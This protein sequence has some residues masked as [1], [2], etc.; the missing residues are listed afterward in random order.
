MRVGTESVSGRANV[1][2]INKKKKGTECLYSVEL[3][4]A[5][6]WE[7]LL[8]SVYYSPLLL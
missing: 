5:R 7:K 3:H 6:Q 4:G 8:I 1:T 2:Y